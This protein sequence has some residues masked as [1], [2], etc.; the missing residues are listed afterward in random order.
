MAEASAMKGYAVKFGS[1]S[2]TTEQEIEENAAP[3]GAS[4]SKP[5]MESVEQMQSLVYQ[6]QAN[7]GFVPGAF[8]VA[9]GAS[10]PEIWKVDCYDGATVALKKQ[11]L[12]RD[13]EEHRLDVSE[14][15]AKWRLHKGSVTSAL[16]GWTPA[17]SPRAS[18][19]W[20]YEAVKGAITIALDR[21]LELMEPAHE[22]VELFS[23][24]NMV[25]S[26]STLKE[27]DLMLAPATMRIDRK[28]TL[29]AICVGKFDIEFGPEPIFISPQFGAPLNKDGFPN[30]NAWVSPFF[31]ARDAPKNKANMSLT[32]F[33]YDVDA[34][35]VRVP[36]LVNTKPLEVG[37]ELVWEKASAKGFANSKSYITDK[38][39]QKGAKRRKVQEA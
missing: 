4:S 36:V 13:V 19:A 39:W 35:E 14:L 18:S 28:E 37:D 15:L 9:E 7:G 2:A 31:L 20:K 12:G 32:I 17:C 21:V 11:I 1:D 25:R 8:V 24:P 33:V 5:A 10:A 30:K 23:N 29:G 22:H 38:H 34:M 27:G 16:P 26:K 3:S 6:A